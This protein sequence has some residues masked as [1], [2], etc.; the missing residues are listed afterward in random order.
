[1]KFTKK[2][3]SKRTPLTLS[4][5]LSM[6]FLET[7]ELRNRKTPPSREPSEDC[8]KSKHG[9]GVKVESE[10]GRVLSELK[11]KNSLIK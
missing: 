4:K 7:L 1:M 10:L 8:L 9:V 11:S 2:D 3:E 5:C 6:N